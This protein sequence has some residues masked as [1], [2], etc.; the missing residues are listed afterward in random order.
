MVFKQNATV[1]GD[2]SKHCKDIGCRYQRINCYYK[3]IVNA[4][5][6]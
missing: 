4:N 3:T 5:I 2:V 1:S 6:Q